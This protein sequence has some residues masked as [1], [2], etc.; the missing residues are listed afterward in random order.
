MLKCGIHFP[1]DYLYTHFLWILYT[2]YIQNFYD[3]HFLLVRINEYKM[4]TKCFY[5]K[6]IPHFENFLYMF[7]KRSLAVIVLL[8]LYIKCIQKLVKK[9]GIH[10]AY[11]L[12]TS[13]VYTLYNLCIQ[14]VY[15]DSVWVY[16]TLWVSQRSVLGPLI[17][18][19]YINDLH[20]Q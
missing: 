14:N 7:C 5:T 3:V 12:Y 6:C 13:V 20:K 16:I 9:C 19:F 4:Y 10:F 15:T 18:L 1:Y 8:I 17:F 11:I 2:N